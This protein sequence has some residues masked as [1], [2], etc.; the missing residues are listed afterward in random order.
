MSFSTMTLLTSTFRQG[1]FTVS[2][3]ANRAAESPID[4]PAKELGNV[5]RVFWARLCTRLSAYRRRRAAAV[6]YTELNKLSDSELE[7]R[8]FARGDLHRVTSETAES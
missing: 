6:L 4:W 1:Q 5:A 8:G 3:R 2:E 7:R